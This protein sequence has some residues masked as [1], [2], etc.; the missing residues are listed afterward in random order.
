MD[1]VTTVVQ[2]IRHSTPLILGTQPKAPSSRVRS[3]GTKGSLRSPHTN[4]ARQVIHRMC[5]GWGAP[6]LPVGPLEVGDRIRVCQHHHRLNRRSTPCIASSATQLGPHFRSPSH[7]RPPC[8]LDVCHVQ[9][10]ACAGS[11]ADGRTVFSRI[12]TSTTDRVHSG[13]PPQFRILKYKRAVL[14][15]EIGQKTYLAKTRP[16]IIGALTH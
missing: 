9:T 3:T 14:G 1:F 10:G 5:D 8:S 2:S 6:S 4:A 15:S 12:G 16:N 7:V 13:D 11:D